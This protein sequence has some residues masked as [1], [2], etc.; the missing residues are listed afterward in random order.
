MSSL[1]RFS[2]K[3]IFAATGL[4]NSVKPPEIRQV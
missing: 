1:A 4:V 2:W 3:P